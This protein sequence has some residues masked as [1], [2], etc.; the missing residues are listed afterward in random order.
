VAINNRKVNDSD[1]YIY[2]FIEE[3][4]FLS[5]LVQNDGISFECNGDVPSLFEIGFRLIREV[6]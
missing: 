3:H 5:E 2:K 4:P 6:Y 1:I